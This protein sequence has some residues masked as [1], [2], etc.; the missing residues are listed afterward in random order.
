MGKT[1]DNVE[2]DDPAENDDPPT[3][4][5]LRSAAES[6]GV[7]SDKGKVSRE[8]LATKSGEPGTIGRRAR[9]ASALAKKRTN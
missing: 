2:T 1:G 9:L 4:V 6:E 8:W 7:V 5:S 3:R